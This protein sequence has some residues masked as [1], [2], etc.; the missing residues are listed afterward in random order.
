MAC[1][2]DPHGAFWLRRQREELLPVPEADNSVLA[3]MQNQ[4]RAGHSFNFTN[5][6]ELVE[7][8]DGPTCGDAESGHERTLDHKA[9]ERLPRSEVY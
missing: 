6:A 9:S 5:T 2:F 7:G 3:T 1:A 4:D 8:R